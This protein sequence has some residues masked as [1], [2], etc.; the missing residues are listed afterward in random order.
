MFS[1]CAWS[2]CISPSLRLSL[3]ETTKSPI[4]PEETY[5]L[6]TPPSLHCSSNAPR[7]HS[8]AAQSTVSM[9]CSLTP[10]CLVLH[11]IYSHHN[12]S[13]HSN[14]ITI[15]LFPFIAI[16]ATFLLA[17]Q[18]TNSFHLL[19]CCAPI[20][21]VN[22]CTLSMDGWSILWIMLVCSFFL[23]FSVGCSYLKVDKRQ[24]I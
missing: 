14:Y 12:K 4:I 11:P 16:E 7:Y 21:I 24:K 10:R 17:P 3:L 8:I 23:S 15:C 20:Q 19:H 13:N 18:S 9:S 22:S 6:L 1:R 2:C 5:K